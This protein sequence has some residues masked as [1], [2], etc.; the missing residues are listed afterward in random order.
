MTA[1]P[2]SVGWAKAP[3]RQARERRAYPPATAQ[4]QVGTLSLCP[5]ETL[6][7]SQGGL[8]DAKPTL[9]LAAVLPRMREDG[10][11]GFSLGSAHPTPLSMRKSP[12]ARGMMR[13]KLLSSLH[14]YPLP[15]YLPGR[16]AAKRGRSPI[17][18]GLG[19]RIFSWLQPAALRRQTKSRR[20]TAL[21][22]ASP[23]RAIKSRGLPG[24]T[25]EDPAS[26][27]PIALR[28]VASPTA[29]PAISPAIIIIAMRKTSA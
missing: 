28:P 10:G 24:K 25:A 29:T 15:P 8:S 3:F 23:P 21:S 17:R 27:T 4:G 14:R 26:G 1:S 20:H 6:M 2:A 11:N 12:S 16:R 5:P 18:R 22:G 13:I 9:A 19:S 7:V